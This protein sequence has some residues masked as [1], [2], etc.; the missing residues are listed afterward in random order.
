MIQRQ[1]AS[2]RKRVRML[3]RFSLVA[4]VFVA[5]LVLAVRLFPGKP[6]SEQVP[7]ST[8]IWS[9]DGEL[10]RVTLAADDQYRLWTPLNDMS[11]ELVEAFLLKEDRWFR[12]HPGVNPV[13]LVRAALRTYT[14]GQRQGGSTLTMQLAR[15][16]Y[17]LKTRTPSG[18]LRQ[19]ARAL[20]LEARY[21]KRQLLEAYLS[22]APFG[23]NIEG[24]G[25]ASRIYFGKPPARV[26][27]GEALT[28]AVIPQRP[29]VRA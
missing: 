16:L 5:L 15:R 9:V 22:L 1:I 19:V 25:A 13:A 29:S 23:G 24:V 4:L 2:A 26:N 10:L 14:G 3:A 21:P 28:L 6:L 8:A 12:W 17:R 20:W 7:L 27:L 18:K 11:P